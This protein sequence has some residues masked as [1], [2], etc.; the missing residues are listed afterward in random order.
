EAVRKARADGRTVHVLPPYRG[1]QKLKLGRLLGVSPYEVA[2]SEALID[3][4]IAQR[5]RK[6][7]EEVDAIERAVG[8]AAEMHRTAMR[9]AQPGRTEW[10]VAGALEGVALAH[11]G[12]LS[13]PSIVSRHGEVLHNH[14]TDYTLREGDLMLVDAGAHAPHTRYASDVT[15]T[16]PVGGRFSERQRGLY[17]AVLAAQEAALAACRP[18]EIG[19]AHV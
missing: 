13:F 1:D 4:V 12:Y 15:R 7:P 10:E 19:R 17:E 5:L 3:A 6:T 16:S 14:P 11:G 2:P 9:M 8:I 18:G